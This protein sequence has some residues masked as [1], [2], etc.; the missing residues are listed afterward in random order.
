MLHARLLNA[1][2]HRFI[3]IRGLC[4]LATAC[5]TSAMHKGPLIR[6]R[7]GVAETPDSVR[8]PAWLL[9]LQLPCTETSQLV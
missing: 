2:M 6:P 5:V 1:H 9:R 4:L 8:C 7:G 3:R